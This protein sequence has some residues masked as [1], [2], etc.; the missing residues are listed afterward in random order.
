MTATG[1]SPAVIAGAL[2]TYALGGLGGVVF[3][4][5]NLPAPFMLGSVLQLVVVVYYLKQNSHQ[6]VLTYFDQIMLTYYYPVINSYC[7]IYYLHLF[8]NVSDTIH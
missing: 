1:Y 4:A 5:L 3:Y 2:R 6:L 7:F 8:R